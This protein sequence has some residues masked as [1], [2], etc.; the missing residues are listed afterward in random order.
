MCPLVYEQ[1]LGMPLHT[2]EYEQFLELLKQQRV[3]KGVSQVELSKRL[4]QTQ[5]YVSRCEVGER[6]LDL[7]EFYQWCEALGVDAIAV[8]EDLRRVLRKHRSFH[9]K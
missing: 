7:I 3:D 4:G 2:P 6:R 9:A 1:P 5:Q 8:F